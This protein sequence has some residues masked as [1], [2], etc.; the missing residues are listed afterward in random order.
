MIKLATA[1][2]H[3]AVKVWVGEHAVVSDVAKS[4]IDVISAKVTS[5]RDRRKINRAMDDFIEAVL[6]RIAPIVEIEFHDVPENERLAALYSL[7]T[8]FAKVGLVEADFISV[9][10]DAGRLQRLVTER[11][12]A[13]KSLLSAGAISLYELLLRECCSYMIEITRGLPVYNSLALTELLRR[14]AEVI[15]GIREILSTLPRRGRGDTFSFDYRRLIQHALDHAELFGVTASDAS[16][17]YRLS[18]AY[19]SLSAVDNSGIM[20]ND[21]A[22]VE[23]FLANGRRWVIRG[24][25][26]LGKT[27]LLQWLA[28]RS[29]LR[30]FTGVLAAWNEDIVPFFLPLRR[31]AE[32][33]L[34]APESFLDEVGRSIAAEMPELW[35]H[36]KL[37]QGSGLVLIDGVDELPNSRR[38]EARKWLK[39]LIRL[40]PRARY[41]V[42]SRPSAMG[43]T[44]LDDETFSVLELQP[45]TPR[46]IEVFIK[47]WHSALRVEC[48]DEESRSELDAFQQSLFERLAE[49]GHLRKL[50][51]YPLLC[52]LL[53]AL[54]RDRRAA[55]PNSRMELYEVALQMLLE[56]LDAERRICAL[57]GLGRAQKLVLLSDLA[58]WFI[59]NDVSD[60]SIDR[61]ISRLSQQL[62]SMPQVGHDAD[63]VFT[64]LLERTGLLRKP[65]EDRVDFVHRTFQEYLAAR[66]AVLD[67]DD[68]GVLVKNASLDQWHEVVVMAVGHASRTQRAELIRG[69]LDSGDRDEGKRETVHLLAMA[70]LETAPELNPDLSK[71]V[72]ER[73][74]RLV[75][76]RS[77]AS[78]MSLAKAGPFV[79]DLLSTANPVEE[80][81]VMATIRAAAETGLSEALS[82][83][84]Q[85]CND[86]RVAV[87]RELIYNWPAFDADYYARAVL[88][89]VEIDSLEIDDASRLLS[90]RHISNLREV[91]CSN[92]EIVESTDL[93]P[94]VLRL[95][96]EVDR[97]VDLSRLQSSSIEE[98]QIRSQWNVLDVDLSPLASVPTLE[99]LHISKLKVGRLATLHDSALRC[100]HLRSVNGNELRS[101]PSMPLELDELS[102][103]D[104]YYLEDL[105]NLEIAKSVR[106]LYIRECASLSWLDGLS[107]WSHS[108]EQLALIDCQNMELVADETI[109]IISQLCE[110]RYLEIRNRRPIDLQP[111]RDCVDSRVV[112]L[113]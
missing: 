48:K 106:A 112:I 32:K 1:A 28:V 59:R 71:N 16:R 56:R 80:N 83:I 3:G 22:R 93:P 14:S 107:R 12:S 60:A 91:K 82:V 97:S 99:A 38:E 13:D 63:V 29:A 87:Q 95:Q 34:P 113:T 72:E 18:V 78:A 45:M 109:G 90:S 61:V 37:R 52:A 8:T 92:P 65:V 105:T 23:S 75:P 73:A 41:I 81:E 108:L 26:G 10:M 42:T 51:R 58:Y 74:E 100:L 39:E 24:E 33:P 62:A 7:K 15:D 89:A 5:E 85:F 31:Y 70:C 43:A 53:C 76:P 19:I 77:M 104:I 101:I 27:T 25:A 86:R 103:T 68:V 9:D 20:R 17:R 47:R 35:V 111:L 54:N 102:L 57:D 67:A 98:L 84:A 44:W 96:L 88:F 110:L 64:H 40:F 69:L 55:L 2:V 6:E 30:D 21:S 66:S 36:D 50:A 79:L 4:A 46:D 11:A 49:R 94:Q